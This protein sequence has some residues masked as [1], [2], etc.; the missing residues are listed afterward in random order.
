MGL[1][2]HSLWPVGLGLKQLTPWNLNTRGN[3]KARVPDLSEGLKAQAEV[4]GS[5]GKCA[6]QIPRGDYE[7]TAETGIRK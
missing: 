2:S 3:Q 1:S 4:C 7:Q 6:G 5:G